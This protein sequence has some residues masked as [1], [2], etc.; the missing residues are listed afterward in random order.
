[1]PI[2]KR[3]VLEKGWRESE[4]NRFGFCFVIQH[5]DKATGKVVFKEALYLADKDFYAQ[6]FHNLFT[7][8]EMHK[9]YIQRIKAMGIEFEKDI[10]EGCKP[11]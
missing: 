6:A 9:E 11:C 3:M 2:I 1:M 7:L 5:I 8:D 4:N 10:N